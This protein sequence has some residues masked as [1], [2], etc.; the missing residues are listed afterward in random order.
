MTPPIAKPPKDPKGKGKDTPSPTGTNNPHKRGATS[1]PPSTPNKKTRNL[2][3]NAGAS[4]DKSAESWPT[5]VPETKY[6]PIPPEY[7]HYLRQSTVC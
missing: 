4:D 2:R 3:S 5:E 7:I 1:D 6:G